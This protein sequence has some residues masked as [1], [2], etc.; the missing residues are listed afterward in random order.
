MR[1]EKG[2]SIEIELPR[3]PW[4]NDYI[5]RAIGKGRLEVISPGP[6]GIVGTEDDIASTTKPTR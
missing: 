4:G 6:D 3:D 2:F 5:L 1:D